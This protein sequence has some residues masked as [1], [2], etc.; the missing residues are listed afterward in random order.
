MVREGLF[1][2]HFEGMVL[3]TDYN[4]PLPVKIWPSLPAAVS[5]AVPWQAKGAC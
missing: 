5:A 4:L 1:S 3:K 2:G